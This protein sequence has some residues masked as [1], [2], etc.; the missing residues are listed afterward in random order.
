MAYSGTVQLLRLVVLGVRAQ[1]MMPAVQKRQQAALHAS[2]YA[3]Y[4][5]QYP[6]TTRKS[7]WQ[8]WCVLSSPCSRR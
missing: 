8:A 2:A 1:V 4:S 7:I 6:F 3:L 5:M